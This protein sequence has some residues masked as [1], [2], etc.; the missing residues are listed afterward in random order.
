MSNGSAAV[1]ANLANA[2][3]LQGVPETG[4]HAVTSAAG[5]VGESN[6]VDPSVLGLNGT[7]WVS[8]A[9]IVF[10]AIILAK[11]GLKAIT[12]GLD[13]QIADI[14]RQLDEAAALRIEAEGLR[15]EYARKL[16]DAEKTAADMTA[17]AEGEAEALVSK[18]SA[19][20]DEL[21]GR[22]AR[23]AEDKIAAAE[24]AALA[25]VRARAADAASR[26]AAALI[27]DRLDAGA[28]RALQDRTISSLGAGLGRP[29]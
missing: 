28:D 2:D 23:M 14:R 26:A 5:G 21:V 16:A 27:A 7:A 13:R 29:N 22:R 17:H 12:G 20:A 19:D 8:I 25:E 11:G 4:H 24:R 18:A 9:M 10:L 15:D 6:H 3:R 1:A